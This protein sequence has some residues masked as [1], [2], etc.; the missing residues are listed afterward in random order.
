MVDGNF[1]DFFRLPVYK[2]IDFSNFSESNTIDYIRVK[3]KKQP[4]LEEQ[5]SS[6]ITYLKLIDSKWYLEKFADDITISVY[7]TGVAHLLTFQCSFDFKILHSIK[8]ENLIARPGPMFTT[9]RELLYRTFS[10]YDIAI[11]KFMGL[12]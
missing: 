8:I 10:N 9:D 12:I 5:I 3:R 6:L 11:Q 4:L 1:F 7:K 2:K